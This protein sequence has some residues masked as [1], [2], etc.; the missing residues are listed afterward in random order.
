MKLKLLIL[1]GYFEKCVNQMVIPKQVNWDED[2]CVNVL[3]E[4]RTSNVIGIFPILGFDQTS[5]DFADIYRCHFD[6]Q[7]CKL[8]FFL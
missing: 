5:Y 6:E 2:K 7:F 8:S 4:I 3:H 1:K